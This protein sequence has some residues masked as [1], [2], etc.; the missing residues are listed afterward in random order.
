MYRVKSEGE[1]D[2]E[3]ML[4][5]QMDSP[6]ADDVSSGGGSPHPHRGAGPPLKKGP[7]T[8]AE[9]AILVDYVKKHGEGNWNAVQKNTGLFRCGKSCRLRWAN[10]LRPNLKKGAFTPEE[11]RLIIQLHAKMGNKWARMAAHLPGRTDNEIKNYWN[12]RIKRCQRASL[13]IYPAS[14]CNQS[15]NEDQQV[16]GDYNGGENISNDLLSGNSLYLP[17]FTSDNFIANPEALSYAPQLSAVS[18]SN[19]LGQSFASKNCSFMDQVD[20]AGMLK[21]SSCVLPALSDAIDGVLSSVDQFSNDSEKLKQALGFDYL[22]EA[23]ASSKSIAP[24]GV[25]LTGSH[26]FLNGNF[27]ASR[28]TN[29]PL[30]MELP[31]LQDT[32]SDPNSWLKYTVAPAMQPTELVDPY[33]QSPSATPSVK[34]ECASPRNSGLLEELLHEAQA[35][36]SGKNQ[37]PSVRS[38]SSSAGT[39]CETTTVVSPEFDMGQEYWEEQPGSFLSEYAHFSGNSLTESTPVSAASP[40]FFQFSKISP[41]QSPS[42]GSGE[43]ALEPKH[44]SAAS[45]HPENLRPDALF[46][47]NTADPSIFNNAIAMLMGNGINAEYKHVLGDGVVLDSS[48]WNNMPH[49]FQM[50]E[51]K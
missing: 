38:S 40:D 47:G 30:K 3:M 4:Q 6:V 28:P 29:G 32:E 16:S 5:D 7:W 48:S 33:L 11:E 10:H 19:L 35:L 51:F 25:A 14:V 42:M 22:N 9:D 26:A 15:S 20:Q 23:N 1:G 17:D 45:P 2:C 46:S 13:P 41:A 24:F 21:Q 36:R 18:I 12:T 39:P 43:Q 37:Q 8:S 50:T 44:E 31:S 27:S 34:S 49:A